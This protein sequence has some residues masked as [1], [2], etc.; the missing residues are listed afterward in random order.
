MFDAPHGAICAALLP[1]TT[2]INIQ[3]LQERQPEGVALQRYEE[4][5]QILTGDPEA[6]V[7]E[8]ATWL[9]ALCQDLQIPGLGAYGLTEADFTEVIDKAKVS[10]S[11]QGNPIKLTEAE[12]AEILKRAL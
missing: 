4:V 8:G 1:H 5:A 9:E 12:M 2:L 6:T 7:I 3:A 10:S 11:M